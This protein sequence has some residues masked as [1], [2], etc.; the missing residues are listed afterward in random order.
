MVGVLLSTAQLWGRGEE[1]GL[2]EKILSLV[3]VH[4]SMDHARVRHLSG[5][6][7]SLLTALATFAT[8]LV[9][10]LVSHT[11]THTHTHTGT[12]SQYPAHMVHS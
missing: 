11:H 10:L 2:Q 4:R 3:D 1:E 12:A 7:V 8:Q 9:L 6:G 5:A